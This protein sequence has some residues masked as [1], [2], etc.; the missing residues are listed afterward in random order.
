MC[1]DLTELCYTVYRFKCVMDLICYIVNKVWVS[2]LFLFIFSTMFQ[3]FLGTMIIVLKIHREMNT[4]KS[5]KP[6][7]DR[8]LSVESI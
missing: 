2:E 3:L 6:P 8:L 4:I 7:F 1:T 5:S